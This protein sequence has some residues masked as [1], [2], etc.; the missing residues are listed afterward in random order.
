MTVD[1]RL[2]SA[3]NDARDAV[4]YLD[5]PPWRR[6][7]REWVAATGSA[8]I[9]LLVGALTWWLAGSRIDEPRLVVDSVPAPDVTTTG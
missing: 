9:L 5:I 2:R 7:R 8:L 6:P 3:A 1:Q 4:R